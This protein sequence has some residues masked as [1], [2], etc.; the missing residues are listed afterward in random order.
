[1]NGTRP[2]VASPF[3]LIH[4]D[5]SGSTCPAKSCPQ[6]TKRLLAHP[7]PPPCDLAPAERVPTAHPVVTGMTTGR[8]KVRQESTGRSS[9]VVSE[10]ERRGSER[11]RV[12][13]AVWLYVR[14]MTGGQ[15]C[16]MSMPF[17]Y[18]MHTIFFSSM[19][20]LTVFI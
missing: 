12:R 20:R 19:L 1:V 6:H 14:S 17:R 5:Q 13:E 4:V 3:L 16:S 11:E 10:E 8:K 15:K 9:L 2:S 18:H 7:V